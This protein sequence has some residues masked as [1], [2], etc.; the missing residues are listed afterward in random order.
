[1]ENHSAAPPPVNRDAAVDALT[2]VAEQHHF[3]AERLGRYQ[4]RY[5]VLGAVLGAAAAS[6]MWRNLVWFGV[7]T[8]LFI[9]SMLPLFGTPARLGVVPRDDGRGSKGLLGLSCLALMAT[10]TVA[11]AGPWWTPI[12]AGIFIAV[13]VTAF[14][15]VWLAVVRAEMSRPAEIGPTGW[16]RLIERLAGT[17]RYPPL[18]AFALGT[19]TVMLASDRVVLSG[20][21]LLVYLASAAVLHGVQTR[22]GEIPPDRRPSRLRMFVPYPVLIFAPHVILLP[23]WPNAWWPAIATG[24]VVA[25]TAV[26]V[27]RWQRFMLRATLADQERPGA[28]R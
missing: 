18:A 24:L 26:A 7:V 6:L 9:A 5:P 13:F 19:A 25:C 14:G 21:A 27:G 16:Q 23:L 2:E 28:G 17:V 3:V 8:V 4:W 10:P 22:I 1:M 11:M 20:A 12:A 15:R